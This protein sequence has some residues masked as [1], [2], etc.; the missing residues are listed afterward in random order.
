MLT[1]LVEA[2]LISALAILAGRAALR[3]TTMPMPY[4]P[5]TRNTRNPYTGHPTSADYAGGRLIG[6]PAWYRTSA[7]PPAIISEAAQHTQDVS[8]D[9]AALRQHLTTKHGAISPRAAEMIAE[10]RRL[11]IEAR[12]ELGA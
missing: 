1:L 10:A 4:T 11:L 2:A 9:A 6:G 8:R 5:T 7:L 3:G 12:A